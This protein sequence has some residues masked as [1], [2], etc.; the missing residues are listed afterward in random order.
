MAQFSRPYQAALLALV[1][2][3]AVWLIALRP[4]SSSSPHASSGSSPKSASTHHIS[5]PGVEGLVKDVAKAHHVVK[6]SEH[7]AEQADGTSVKAS[8]Q[9]SKTATAPAA[10]AA[11]PAAPNDRAIAARSGAGRTPARQALVERALAE[12]KPAVILFWNPKGSDDQAV[13]LELT[14]L[15]VVHHIARTYAH[16]RAV[17][18]VMKREG[19]QLNARFAAFVAKPNEVS[20]FGTIT[21]DVQLYS[22]PAV[23]VVGKDRQAHVLDGLT[24]A[25]AMQQTLE[26]ARGSLG[27]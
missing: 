19:M 8:G 13:R 20:S 16:V 15:E 22:T 1:V 9:A 10:S 3:A 18:Q 6:V 12:G 25:F 27:S 23:V 4:H 5:A 7:E 24:D 2:L 17:E 21:R 14:I 11:Q 26:E